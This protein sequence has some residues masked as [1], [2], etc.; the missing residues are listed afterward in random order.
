MK[1]NL[2]F[3]CR[4]VLLGM[5]YL[6]FTEGFWVAGTLGCSKVTG[7]VILAEFQITN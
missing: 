1:K 6:T 7:T 5:I 2:S 4:S 3:L